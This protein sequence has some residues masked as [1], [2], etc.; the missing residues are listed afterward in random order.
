M[1]TTIKLFKAVP[2]KTKGT[3]KIPKEILERTIPMGYTFSPEVAKN[4]STAELLKLANDIDEVFGLNAEQL[5]NTFHKSWY[6]VKHAPMAQLIMEQI[7]HYIT[8]YGFEE[9]GIYSEGSVYIPNELLEIPDLKVDKLNLIVIQGYTKEQL[10][11]KVMSLVTSGVALKDETMTDIANIMLFV[12]ISEEDISPIK[13]HE[14]K[15][16]LYDY[17]DM[18]PKNPVDFLRYVLYKSCEKTLLIKN[19]GTIEAIKEGNNMVALTLFKKYEM[20]YGFE[21]LASIFHRFKPLFLAY[22]TGT[23]LKSII[24]KIRRLAVKHHKPMPEDYLNTVTGK[25][26][27]AEVDVPIL[28]KALSTANLFR[29]IRLAYALKFRTKEV[30]SILYRVRNGKGYAKE[31]HYTYHSRAKKALD[32]VID[33]IVE[34]MKDNVKGKKI[35]I[36]S[37]VTYA[38]PSTEKQFSGF[39][40]T[41]TSVSVPKDMVFGVHWEN[42]MNH[43]IDLDLSLVNAMGK[44]GWDAG[45]RSDR[46]DVLFSGDITDAPLPKGATELFYVQ[47]QEKQAHIMMCN[48]YNYE[49]NL[50]VPFKIIVAEEQVSNLK[51]NYTVDPNNVVAISNSV[52][53]V[54]QKALGLIVTTTGETKFYFTEINLGDSITSRN[55]DYVEHS[56]NYLFNYYTNTISLN[57]ILKKAGAVIVDKLCK[58]DEKVDIDLTIERLEKDTILNLLI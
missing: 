30:E 41:G 55:N 15:A 33:S 21:G 3:K 9:L 22:K 18:F 50:P 4:Y 24:N 27:K 39:L 7:I 32:V 19:Q 51:N 53:D 38:L 45:Y 10:K 57:D 49:E 23:Q 44:L 12:G 16:I 36:P 20:K 40:P 54:K 47:S 14:I 48:Y 6:K 26:K 5:T 28:K 8:T 25:L 1:N 46:R 42:Q 37:N 58:E 35:Y 56:K 11:E 43:R 2:I 29:K 34:S 31:F 13:N 17:L 52:I